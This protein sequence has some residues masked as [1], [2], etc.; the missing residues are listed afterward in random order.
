MG[1]CPRCSALVTTDQRFCT[2]CGA[3]LRSK[4][5]QELPTE[6]AAQI[7]IYEKKIAQEPLNLSL[8]LELGDIYL[9]HDL[10]EQAILQYQK[11]AA[12]DQNGYQA[13]LKSA[14]AYSRLS[15]HK[16]ALESYERAAALQPNALEPKLGRFDALIALGRHEEAIEL[17]TSLLRS[18][19]QALDIRRRVGTLLAEVGRDAEAIT[20]LEALVAT[21]PS[22]VTAQLTLG[23]LYLR[24]HQ[25][26]KAVA[27]F[28]K[29]VE[30]QPESIEAK[31]QLGRLLTESAST[32]A[33]AVSYLES[34]SS[35]DPANISISAMLATALIST[36][37][38]SDASRLLDR[39]PLSALQQAPQKD[40]Q[41]LLS[42]YIRLAAF[43]L[44]QNS[45]E[46]A[47]SRL[48]QARWLGSSPELNHLI[49]KACRQ[50][51]ERSAE[52][53]NWRDA[54]RYYRLALGSAPDDS[55]CRQLLQN[56]RDRLRRQRTRLILSL[57]LP[58]AVII[59]L[60]G[61]YYLWQRFGFGWLT[62]KW[63]S[64]EVVSV[65]VD[66]REWIGTERRVRQGVHTVSATG[67]PGFADTTFTVRVSGNHRNAVHIRARNLVHRLEGLSATASSSGRDYPPANAIDGDTATCWSE[68]EN[69]GCLGQWL[70]VE[71]PA[72]THITRIGIYAGY[73][74]P[75][76]LYGSLYWLNNRLR[77]V[78]AV[79]SDGTTR[80]LEFPDEQRRHFFTFNPPVFTRWVRFVVRGYYEGAL[81]DDLCIS[82]IE[83]WGY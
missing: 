81:W 42:A 31:L 21:S 34:L 66:G 56:A 67:A 79:F 65:A 28:R 6:L 72:E 50:L 5:R 38:Y 69:T 75:H 8:Y 2:Q 19:P 63:D 37:R 18:L 12:I 51:G 35:Q 24:N 52:K 78:E 73:G 41:T 62:L 68:A 3:P 54:T 23:R 29:V 57:T 11:A 44:E 55:E 40:R 13:Q 33:E 32:A 25:H 77:Q 76:R 22:D 7:E 60:G 17:G 9:K 47:L 71:F 10:A 58:V 64:S 20:S 74:K 82:E 53:E 83:F 61:A 4:A 30:I 1:T 70:Q 15:R 80:T 26:E 59:L 48:N 16:L 46:Q 39:L 49:A 14:Q 36:G 43:L 27:C 45:P